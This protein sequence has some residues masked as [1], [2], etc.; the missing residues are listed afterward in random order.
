VKQ[1]QIE[2][3]VAG[4]LS[5]SEAHAFE[6]YCVANPEFARQV[7]IEQ[8]LKAGLAQVARGSTSEFVRSESR[9]P[10]R[11]AAAAAGVLFA[12]L[13]LFYVLHRHEPRADGAIL[14][15]VTAD[16]ARGVRTQRLALVRGHG[17]PALESGLVKVEI[18]GLFDQGFL[19][20]VALDRI[21]QQKN[22]ETVATVF[23]VQP[24]SPVT[25]EVMID[26]DRLPPGSYSL[27]V[28]KQTSI[29]EPLDFEFLRH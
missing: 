20:S 3:Y 6:D 13:S 24:T 2:R 1:E 4:R 28:R 21:D 22:I 8:R 27:R 14:A 15:A 5:E 7:E 16:S 18:A 23:G 25:L 12:L 29:E 11:L 26:S 10:W 17:K 9:V 19:Y